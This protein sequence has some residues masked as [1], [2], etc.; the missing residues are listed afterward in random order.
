MVLERNE[1]SG[2]RRNLTLIDDKLQS[3]ELFTNSRE[4]TIVH[5]GENYKL[6]LTGNDRL[7]LNK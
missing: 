7:I 5:K 4:I 2:N 1:E 3:D 6:R